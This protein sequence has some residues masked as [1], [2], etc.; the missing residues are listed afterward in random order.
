MD[1]SFLNSLRFPNK[2]S[3]ETP[4][5]IWRVRAFQCHRHPS[6]QISE[7]V[8]SPNRASHQY[9]TTM[10]TN[11]PAHHKKGSLGPKH[12]IFVPGKFISKKTWRP[13]HERYERLQLRCPKSKIIYRKQD[14]YTRNQQSILVPGH[15]FVEWF[16]YTRDRDTRWAP[17]RYKWSFKSYIPYK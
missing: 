2:I 17:A 1:Y 8:L 4:L 14:I 6:L 15:P 7:D 3:Q 13:K 5:R 12:L 16:I 10:H 9:S 11:A